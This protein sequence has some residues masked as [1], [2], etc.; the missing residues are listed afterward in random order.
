MA[1]VDEPGYR[2]VLEIIRAE[3]GEVAVAEAWVEGRAMSLDEAVAYA[4]SPEPPGAG[5]DGGS[6]PQRDRE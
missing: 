5:D 1:P 4:L 6:R 2:R 3:V